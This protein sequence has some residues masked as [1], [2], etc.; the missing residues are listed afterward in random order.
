MGDLQHSTAEP[1]K[2][3]TKWLFT[4]PFIGLFEGGKYIDQAHRRC[5]HRIP[6][7]GKMMPQHGVRG[8]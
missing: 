5:Q 4:A 3:R 7:M 2:G 1:S 6:A 8:I